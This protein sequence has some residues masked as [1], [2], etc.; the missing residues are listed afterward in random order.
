LT[1][2]DVREVTNK[3]I[4]VCIDLIIFQFHAALSARSTS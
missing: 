4:S 1:G 2:T 3:H